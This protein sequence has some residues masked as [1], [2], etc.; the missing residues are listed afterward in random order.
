MTF[1]I[2]SAA[3]SMFTQ[4]ATGFWQGAV[5][6]AIVGS[7]TG[8]GGAI[9]NGLFNGGNITLKE[10]LGGALI[11]GAIGAVAG[12]IKGGLNAQK[13]GL[14]FWK[15]QGVVSE[16]LA[17]PLPQ[18]N[19][20]SE[21]VEYS[22]QS[23]KQFSAENVELNKHSVNVK[24][25]QADGTV[26]NAKYGYTYNRTTGLYIN[27][28]GENVAGI[29]IFDS[30]FSKKSTVYL[31]KF[32]F[33]S[34]EQLYLTMNHEYMHAK[35]YSLGLFNLNRNNG[36]TI[37]HNFEADQI[38]MWGNPSLSKYY[39][40]TYCGNTNTYSKYGFNLISNLPK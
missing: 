39:P 27:E 40:P 17:I 10:V 5:Q 20:A 30:T 21:P 16:Q 25:L 31:A 23:A 7:I 6:G 1:G 38:S 12:G 29:T 11:G 3:G 35:F 13:N 33:S 28:K 37:I 24:S 34:K 36:H 2:G 8:A 26:P 14:S 9:V 32:A 15:G 19:T 22:N 4:A 18:V